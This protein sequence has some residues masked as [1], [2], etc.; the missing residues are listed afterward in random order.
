MLLYCPH[1]SQARK[2][3]HQVCPPGKALTFHVLEY[4]GR[5]GWHGPAG[6]STWEKAID[7]TACSTARRRAIA[8]NIIIQKGGTKT[9]QEREAEQRGKWREGT[10]GP[11]EAEPSP[12]MGRGPLMAWGAAQ[13]LG[14]RRYQALGGPICKW[15]LLRKLSRL[16][17]LSRKERGSF[18]PT[19][20]GTVRLPHKGR[21]R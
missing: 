21:I 7:L 8:K 17:N 15:G 16:F 3:P 2:P 5:T 14:H 20:L 12:W 11:T 4:S 18:H 13:S 19:T 1:T 6:N 10:E 9:L